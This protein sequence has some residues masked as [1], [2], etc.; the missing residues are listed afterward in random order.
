LLGS[1]ITVTSDK[2]KEEYKVRIKTTVTS[3]VVDDTFGYYK[4]FLLTLVGS[5]D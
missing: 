5:E 1:E 3:D 2:I 4:D